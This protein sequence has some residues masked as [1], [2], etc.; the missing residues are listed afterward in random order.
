MLLGLTACGAATSQAVDEPAPSPSVRPT[1]FRWAPT[2]SSTVP[3]SDTE[4][5][6]AGSDRASRPERLVL[7]RI[8]VP[9]VPVGVADDGM[10]ELPTTAYA[11]GWYKFGARPADRSGT[12]VL[13]GHVD[14]RKEGLGPLA[15]LRDV[16]R[17][18]EIE[19]R[20][21]DGTSHRYRVSEV[22]V[23][24]KARVPLEQIFVRDGAETLVV[25]TCGGPYDPSAGY[26]DNVIVTARPVG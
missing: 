10:M 8:D 26:R 24:R 3:V 16:D 5:S 19:L 2:A 7:G 9:V 23:I 1:P 21:A 4:P 14:T 22:K 13:A 17:G 18:A 15:G 12:T 20:A 11:I 25:I 6:A